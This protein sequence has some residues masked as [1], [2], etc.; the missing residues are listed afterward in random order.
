[1][2]EVNAN[3]AAFNAKQIADAMPRAN[4]ALRLREAGESYATIGRLLGVSRER[5]RQL[6]AKALAMAE[7]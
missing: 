4:R 5:A 3:Q 2:D 7:K 6:A 1:M